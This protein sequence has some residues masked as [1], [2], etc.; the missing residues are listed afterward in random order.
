MS[1]SETVLAWPHVAPEAAPT[2]HGRADQA[3]PPLLEMQHVSKTY[4]LGEQPVHALRDVSVRIA[5]GEFVAVMGASGGGKSTLMNILGCLDRPTDGSYLLDGRDVATL[6]DDEQAAVRN[7]MIGFVFQS[8]NLLPRTSALKNVELPLIYAGVPPRERAER[9]QAAL[10]TVGLSDRLD[11]Q[12]SQLSG[13]Q[14]QRVAVARALVGDTPIIM[15]DE[16][17]GNLDSQVTIEIMNLLQSLNRGRGLTLIL[18][19]HEPDVAAYASR[20]LRMRDGRVLGDT[21][22]E[23]R[24]GAMPQASADEGGEA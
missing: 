7:R 13:G 24:R 5:W 19:T 6:S 14:Q 4:V 11:H 17:T 23:P 22:Q 21:R 9:A 12:P 20:I 3:A 18:V 8:F 10:E 15:A 16:P 1:A 2:S